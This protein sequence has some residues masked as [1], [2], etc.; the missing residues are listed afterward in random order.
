MILD[1]MTE[2]QMAD[3][4]QEMN[5]L[6]ERIGNRR[7]EIYRE[8]ETIEECIERN[9]FFRGNGEGNSSG[10]YRGDAVYRILMRTYRD[11]EE[12]IEQINQEL[13]QMLEEEE[14]IRYIRNCLWKLPMKQSE[15][16]LDLYVNGM[17]WEKYAKRNYVSRATVFRNRK[18]AL[19]NLLV[20]YNLRFAKQ[21]KKEVPEIPDKMND[22]DRGTELE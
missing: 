12:Q 3:Y 14:K 18:T 9:T 4:L 19:K 11:Y 8:V 7:K 17:K 6:E 22:N 2:Q 1:A 5:R 16:L 13:L 15:I 20:I 21:K 10:H